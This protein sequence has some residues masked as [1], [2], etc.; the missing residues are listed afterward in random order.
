[1][2]AAAR[3]LDQVIGLVIV[4]AQQERVPFERGTAPAG[5]AGQRLFP[6]IHF[7]TQPPTL[8]FSNQRVACRVGE[9]A[10]ETPRM[11]P[12][13]VTRNSWTYLPRP[14]VPGRRGDGTQPAG[15][16]G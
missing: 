12:V 5:Q 3:F 8:I 9:P 7:T 1:M 16:L 13:I 10:G 2:S 14:A 6:A 4:A 11:P 15:D